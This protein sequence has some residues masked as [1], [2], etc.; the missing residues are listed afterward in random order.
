MLFRGIN[1]SFRCFFSL[2]DEGKLHRELQCSI[3]SFLLLSSRHFCASSVVISRSGSYTKKKPSGKSRDVKS[4]RFSYNFFYMF[5]C[6]A[7]FF[8][9]KHCRPRQQQDERM[10]K[11]ERRNVE[12]ILSRK[13]TKSMKHV[14]CFSFRFGGVFFLWRNFP[15]RG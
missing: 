4:S 14:K 1:F 6:S 12:S 11:E 13:H 7:F 2:R 5:L 3:F 9:G 10:R 8:K 15:C